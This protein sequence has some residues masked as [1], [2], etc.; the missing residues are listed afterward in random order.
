MGQNSPS[1]AALRKAV[2]TRD[3]KTM[4]GF[5]AADAVLTVIDSDN[6]PSRPRTIKGASAIGSFYDDVCG[7]DM[8]HK[9]EFGALEGR[10]LAFV[11]GCAYPDGTR[12]VASSTAELGPDGIVKQTTVQAWDH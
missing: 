1:I 11:Q 2:E 5:Y 12:V 4:K 3:S 8:T 10:H 9:L 6:P 7:R